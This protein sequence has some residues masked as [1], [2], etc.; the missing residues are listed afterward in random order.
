M[1]ELEPVGADALDAFLHA[2][3][4]AFHDEPQAET[5]ALWARALDPERTLAARD[6]GAIVATSALLDLE[7]TVPGATVPAAG[8][9][10]VGVN[11][12]HRG[13]GLLTRMMRAHLEAVHE[14][15]TE[16]VA[17]LWA[18]E[19]GLYGRYGFGLA[20]RAADLTVRSADARLL[21]PAPE[22][23]RRAGT[24]AELLA[25][26]RVVYDAV[27]TTRPGMLARTDVGWDDAISD[28]EPDR[29]GAGRLRAL[30]WDGPAGP[31]GYALYAIRKQ[32]TAGRPDDVVELRE[33]IAATPEAA[34]ATWEHLLRLAL[35]RSVHW[36]LAPED[37]PLVHMVGDARAVESRLFDGMYV[38]LVDVPRALAQRTYGAPIDV[39][40][41]VADAVCPW[42]AGRWRLAADATGATCERTD[43]PADLALS[44][45]ELG[46]AH[47]GGTTLAVLAAA[48]RVEER[49]PDAVTT[50]SQAFQGPR[51][52][53]CP[54]I[55]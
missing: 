2:A 55:F 43:A 45:T 1:A 52:P 47:L 41:D 51:S 27:R 5:L 53:W 50:A 12:L 20:T 25:D 38:R 54:E 21:T 26:V 14:R 46:A 13:R 8:V 44:A 42:N 22:S 32:E 7:L 4:D 16:A 33:L 28:F 9:T 6:G 36:E 39:V 49:T 3:E 48:G 37:E 40:L 19:A 30:V 17:A 23:G 29:K 35:S 31:A 18:S 10:A 11:A 15:G 24:P 34:A